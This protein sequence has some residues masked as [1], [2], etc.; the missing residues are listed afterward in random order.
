MSIVEKLE[1]KIASLFPKSGGTREPLELHR[2]ALERLA[3]KSIA[4]LRG[5]RVFPFDRVVLE[6]GVDDAERQAALKTLFEP[7]TFAAHIRAELA[8]SR[9]T[10]PAELRVT[11]VFSA[12]AEEEMRITC[13]KTE[14]PPPEPEVQRAPAPFT[15]ARLAVLAGTASEVEFVCEKTFLNVGRE[16]SVLDS[17]GR[18]IRRNDLFFIGDDSDTNASVSRE[19]AHL[20]FDTSTGEWR[21]YDDGSRYGTAIFRAGRRIVVPP[22]SARGAL[23]KGGDEVFLGEARIGFQL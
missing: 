20:R 15:P 11:L 22:H 12:D 8:S 1:R 4:G 19:H 9:I 5:E 17:E 23:L 6:F 2:E 7:T 21:I 18:L 16:E 3:A 14:P 10:P 13:E